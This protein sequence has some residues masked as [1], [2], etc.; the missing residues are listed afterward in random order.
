MMSRKLSALAFWCKLKGFCDV[1]KSFMVRQAMKGFRKGSRTRDSRCPVSFDL[2]LS[3][4]DRLLLVCDDSFELALFHLAFSLAF[5]G[6]FCI[7]ELVSSS[8]FRCGGLVF[9]DVH[10]VE[11]HLRCTLRKSE[12]D[13][14]GRGHTVVLH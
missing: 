10:L 9:L 5:F 13:Q 6:A 8:R 4:G 12:T 3:L 11:G 14:Q 7:S 2:L 1:T